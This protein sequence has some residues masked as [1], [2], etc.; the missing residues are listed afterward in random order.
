MSNCRHSTWGCKINNTHRLCNLRTSQRPSLQILI[1]LLAVSW[2][3]A[4]RLHLAATVIVASSRICFARVLG[5]RSSLLRWLYR[6][7]VEFFWYLWYH[8][9]PNKA[10]GKCCKSVWNRHDAQESWCTVHNAMNP[11]SKP[12]KHCI[13]DLPSFPNPQVRGIPLP[14][15]RKQI[16]GTFFAMFWISDV[17]FNSWS[18]RPHMWS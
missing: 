4:I 3:L 6:P 10:A 8:C 1:H 18:Q 5:L 13:S 16:K 12:A 14:H 2:L 15:F 7:R 9:R 11:E 17:A